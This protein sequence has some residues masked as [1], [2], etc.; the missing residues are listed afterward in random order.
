MNHTELEKKTLAPFAVGSGAT[1]GRKHPEAEHAYRSPFQRDRDRII[2]S[3]AFRRLE[4]KTQV[5]LPYEGDYYRTRLTHSIEVAQIGRTIGRALALNEDLT[6]AVALA[7]DLGHPPFGHKGEEVLH[8]LMKRHGG[9]EHNSQSLRIVDLLETRYPGFP[10]LNL[11]HEVREGIAKHETAFDL[12]E[13]SLR[14]EELP[15]LEAQTVNRADEI[16]YSCHDTD[17]GLKSGILTEEQFRQLEICGPAFDAMDAIPGAEAK[18]R[19]CHLVRILIDTQ[20][21]DLLTQT[22]L[23]IE[24]AG[25]KTFDDVRSC[26]RKLVCFSPDMERATSE[27]RA[28]LLKNFYKSRRVRDSASNARKCLTALFDFYLNN[29]EKLPADIRAKQ[30]DDPPHRIVCDY[31]AGMTDRFALREY[32]RLVKKKPK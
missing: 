32:S 6:E 26:G 4:F 9:F 16:T 15:T 2:H 29:I 18:M 5:F 13:L 19:R 12:P 30:A 22:R 23:N 3:S 14:A 1:Q 24:A 10:G 20:V 21:T 17:D 25:I 28:F 7:H 8:E 31:M 11:T 27:L